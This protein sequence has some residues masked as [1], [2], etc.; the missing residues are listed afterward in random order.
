[1]VNRSLAE[2][3]GVSVVPLREA[4]NRLASEGLLKLIPGAGAFVNQLDQQELDELCVLRAALESAAAAEAAQYISPR[5]LSELD[6]LVE[7][8]NLLAT[9]I[10]S[11]PRGQATKAQLQRWMK[12]EEQFHETVVAASRNRFLIKVAGEQR[13]IYRVFDAERRVP[14]L[15]TAEIADTTCRKHR[16]LLVALQARDSDLARQLMSEHIAMTRTHLATLGKTR[17]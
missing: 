16:E 14:N 13:V 3:F 9:E 12:N 2:E 11:H 10:R 15:L 6:L 17:S 5:Q 8:W 1:M 4:I 7:D